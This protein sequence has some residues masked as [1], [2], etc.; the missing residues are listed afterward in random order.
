M[1]SSGAGQNGVVRILLVEDETR[2]A[3]F[4]ARGLREQA[5]AVDVAADAGPA[6]AELTLAI[7]QFFASRDPGG[8][9]DVAFGSV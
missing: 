9:G 6:A 8:Y 4:I 2:V 3:G 1:R 7:S 5:Y